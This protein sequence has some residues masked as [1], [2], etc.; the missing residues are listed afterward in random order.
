MEL[1]KHSYPYYRPVLTA[2]LQK[3]ESGE[4][5]VPDSSPDIESIVLS[6][7]TACIKERHLQNG[8]LEFQ[9]I[10]KA[11]VL[12]KPEGQNNLRKLDIALPFSHTL[13]QADLDDDMLAHIVPTVLTADTR[14]LNPRKVQT[15]V[16]MTLAVDV[17]A[18]SDWQV[19]TGLAEPTDDL[20]LLTDVQIATMP[21]AMRVKDFNV[22]DEIELPS[23]KPAIGELLLVN[24]TPSARDVK[25]IG[26]KI[27]F[28]GLANLQVAYSTPDDSGVV[29]FEQELPFS[30]ILEMDGVEENCDCTVDL[31]LTGMELDVRTGVSLDARVLSFTLALQAYAV[32]ALE[33]RLEVLTDAYAIG[34]DCKLLF[35]PYSF[36]QQQSQ[37][38]RHVQVRELL[39]TGDDVNTVLNAC[40]V[41]G[42]PV[43]QQGDE[44]AALLCDAFVRVLYQTESG[45][46]ATVN[47]RLNVACPVDSLS[48]QTMSGRVN[49][50]TAV[51]TQGGL[52]V[53]FTAE[54][55][56]STPL[57]LTLQSLDD[58][59]LLDP[60]DADTPRPSV[61]LRRVRA[62]DKLWN[63]AK[64][65]K[66]TVSDITAANNL[67]DGELP[68]AK[69]LLI[70]KKR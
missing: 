14:L 37:T 32:A 29:T 45:Q 62:G 64:R 34:N 65:Y 59:E 27:V 44:Q 54:F 68:T 22:T 1:N 36:K 67:D 53:R 19:S 7:G 9:G 60:S 35:K 70:P 41:L 69:M 33:R 8:R 55:K 13:E 51:G 24:V 18:K 17:S 30:Q 49:D 61:V 46:Y 6:T 4:A 16:L 66:T 63:I 12:Y 38:D 40:V 11:T 20:Q 28:K 23:N 48:W 47:R 57:E 50:I 25:V 31:Q 42:T 5:I 15:A 43:V 56:L 21:V 39:E 26:N 2:T 10:I 52:E 58:I 3:E